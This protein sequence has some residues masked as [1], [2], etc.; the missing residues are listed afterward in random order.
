[1]IEFLYWLFY[2]GVLALVVGCLAYLFVDRHQSRASRATDGEA[3][4]LSRASAKKAEALSGSYRLSDLETILEQLGAIE[5]WGMVL[6]LKFT[7]VQEDLQM[8]VNRNEVELCAP[9]LEPNDTDLFRRVAK[10]VGLQARTGYTE[11]QYCVDVM[12]TWPKIA[13]IIRNIS[14]SIYG[15]D[16]SEEVQV[17]VFN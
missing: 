13:S 7:A 10:E 12:G 5:A 4:P 15:V 9:S 11:G 8:I 16:D 3:A 17:R 2:L 6:E 1:M 14:R